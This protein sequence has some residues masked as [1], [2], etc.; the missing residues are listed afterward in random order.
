MKE[1]IL[2]RNWQVVLFNIIIIAC[3]I[4]GYGRFGDVFVDSFREFYIPEQMLNGQSLYK[5]IFVIYPPFAYLLNAFLFFIFGTK[6]KVFYITG[7]AAVL[8]ILNLVYKLSSKFIDK[9]SSLGIVLFIISAGCLSPNVFN[10]FVPYSFGIL[11]GILFVLGSLYF[12]LE[13]KYP[14]A[15]FLYSLAICSKYEF[16]LL[17]P[18][19]F[20]M[21][22]KRDLI[23]NVIAFLIP[24]VFTVTVLFIQGVRVNDIILAVHFVV[25]MSS[26]KTLY[27]FYS[28]SGLIFRPEILPVY[29][30]NIIKYAIPFVILYFFRNFF[31][32]V[33]TLVYLYFVINPEIFIYL[34][35][36]I[37]VFF[38]INFRKSDKNKRFFVAASI[39]VSLKI[40]FAL[41]L[42]SYGVYFLPFGLIALFIT[43]PDKLK[44]P[45]GT[46]IICAAVILGIKNV[47]ALSLKKEKI[48]TRNGVVYIFQHNSAIKKAVEFIENKTDKDDTIIVLPEG[49]SVNVLTGRKSDNKFYSLIPLYVETFGEDLIIERLEKT[50]PEYILITNYDTSNYYYSSFGNDYAKEIYRFISDNYANIES[51]DDRISVKIFKLKK[52]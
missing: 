25:G 45:L 33:I 12:I 5:D 21:S 7:L 3:F 37:A 47:Q 14:I 15:Y 50:L 40:F 26:A 29:A 11:Y 17:F 48:Q 28:V 41:T 44:K 18:L 42:Q 27:W 38:V 31:T 32:C 35:P 4:F 30:V 8:G 1:G 9:N 13:E 20:W 39:L 43:I 24:I 23:K 51:I 36:L 10:L 2:K 49:L 34:F 19:L 16:I 46:L 52:I 22:G 6:L